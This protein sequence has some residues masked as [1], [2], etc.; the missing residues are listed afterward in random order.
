MGRKRVVKIK[1]NYWVPII[2]DIVLGTKNTLND[3]IKIKI[4][5]SLWDFPWVGKVHW[6]FYREVWMGKKRGKLRIVR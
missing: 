3:K 2:L 4:A 6:Q 1:F 5:P